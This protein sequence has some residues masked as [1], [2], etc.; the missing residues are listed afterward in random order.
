MQCTLKVTTFVVL[1]SNYTQAH[2]IIILA[3]QVKASIDS[4]LCFL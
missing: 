3:V 1:Q 2:C 4:E